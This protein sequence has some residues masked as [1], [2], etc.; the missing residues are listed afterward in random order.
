[1]RFARDSLSGVEDKGSARG[2][3][4]GKSDDGASFMR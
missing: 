2:P 4:S 1:V 3:P